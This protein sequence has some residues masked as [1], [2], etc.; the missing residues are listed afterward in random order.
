MVWGTGCLIGGF[1]TIALGW[2]SLIRT[3]QLARLAQAGSSWFSTGRYEAGENY[4]LHL[5]TSVVSLPPHHRKGELE[6]PS[7]FKLEFKED[8]NKHVMVQRIETMECDAYFKELQ[9][10]VGQSGT[11]SALVYIHGYNVQFDDALMRMAQLAVDMEYDGVPI[12]YSWPSRGKLAMYTK[13][14][15]P[16]PGRLPIWK[17]SCWMFAQSQE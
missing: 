15:A 6:R 4:P 5:G 3:Q 14:E 12:L 7:I 10:K 2:Q 17:N 11:Q 1:I 13:D 16:L 8:A 9:T